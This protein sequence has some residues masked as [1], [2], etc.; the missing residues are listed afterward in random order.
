[1]H[2]N[3]ISIIL[4]II[5]GFL[6]YCFGINAH[7][8]YLLWVI[9]LD[10]ILGVLA[11]FINPRLMFNSRKMCRGICKKI[12]IL[13]LVMF[14]HQL[15]VMLCT[16]TLITKVVTWYY[17]AN[18]GLSCLENAGKCGVKYPEILANSL[19]QLKEIT[20]ANKKS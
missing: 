2:E 17:I 9:S 19:E 13:T 14:A 16:D 6:S 10:I 20:N 11:S 15:D 3:S 7:L 4:G 18:E 5:G 1:M 12:V 8:E